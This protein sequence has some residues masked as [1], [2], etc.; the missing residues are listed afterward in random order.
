MKTVWSALFIA[1]FVIA[2]CGIASGGEEKTD[3]P[4]SGG[5]EKPQKAT[6]EE[7]KKILACISELRTSKLEDWLGSEPGSPVA[8]GDTIL[9]IGSPAVPFIIQALDAHRTRF[10]VRMYLTHIMGQFAVD[11][12]YNSVP[13]L[14]K[15][16]ESY[17]T[18]VK[19]AKQKE[20]YD[21]DSEESGDEWIVYN[22]TQWS[23]LPIRTAA[24]L[25]AIG[26]PKAIPTLSKVMGICRA[27]SDN[28]FKPNARPSNSTDYCWEVLLGSASAIAAIDDDAAQKA[29]DKYAASNSPSLRVASNLMKA[30]K[31]MKDDGKAAYD[32]LK[33]QSESE[34]VPKA[35]DDYRKF[36]KKN[37][38]SYATEADLPPDDKDTKDGSTKKE[39]PGKDKGKDKNGP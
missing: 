4:A 15:E 29:I 27:T 8:A 30:V 35:R 37:L 18:N 22:V 16:L 20:A 36:I 1:I 3:Q 12:K 7:A 28:R 38:R 32:F 24:E 6:P 31:M 19:Y 34:K 10:A 17:A 13:F 23:Y 14:C 2:V 26:D 11:K 21:L 25:A 5:Y 9:E 33:E 39:N